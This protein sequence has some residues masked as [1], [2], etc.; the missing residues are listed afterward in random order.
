MPPKRFDRGV[1]RPMKKPKRSKNYWKQRK[2]VQIAEVPKS[3][4]EEDD[5]DESDVEDGAGNDAY[6]KLCATFDTK[7]NVAVESEEESDDDSSE[8]ED[9][10][11]QD[12]AASSDVDDEEVGEES[13]DEDGDVEDSPDDN[14]GVSDE[15]SEDEMAIEAD[16]D[17]EEEA[18]ANDL[19]GGPADP[20]V[21]RYETPEIPAELKAAAESRKYA[22]PPVRETFKKIGKLEAQIPDWRP[23]IEAAKSKKKDR[24]SKPKVALDGS[25]DNESAKKAEAE[26]ILNRDSMLTAGKPLQKSAMK[27]DMTFVKAQLARNV[28]S[29]NRGF[30]F[31]PLQ[32][33]LYS[34][35]SSYRDL[36]YPERTFENAEEIRTVYVLHALN[37]VLK[38]RTRIL[39]NNARLSKAAKPGEMECRDQGLVR[40]KVLIVVPFRE[41]A[42]RVV[43]LM[44]R[45]LFGS[46]PK[47]GSV[48]NR[49]RFD[50][51][52]DGAEQERR[53]KPDDF[54]DTFSGNVDDGFNLGVAVTK[55]T[56]KLYTDF[57]SSDVIISSPLG[58]RMAVGTE[59]DRVEDQNHD[60]LASL[61]LLVL[62]QTDVFAMQNW[63]HV[64]HLFA[65]LH[66]QPR[67]SHGVDFTR[68]RLWTLNGLSGLYRQTLFFGHVP[69]AE[70]GALFNRSCH[71][72][73][74]RV[75][76]CNPVSGGDAA[77]GRVLAGVP[78]AFHRFDT[79]SV[80][81]SPGHRLKYF[82]SR[83]MPE[84]KKDVMF[85][86]CV[87]VPSYFDYVE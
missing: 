45:L 85:H 72:Y 50:T 17:E 78:A 20:F 23:K 71:N 35:V 13:E 65:Y 87:F 56:L 84:Y 49:V 21:A 33:E 41:S 77:I 51:E 76:V 25:E 16:G 59:E 7:K 11:E 57:Y 73:M 48:A 64:T 46:D 31:S 27:A 79:D 15:E 34:L 63:E 69:M 80:T 4:S 68:V 52:F 58:L 74:G 12:V 66:R 2:T 86:T 40:P 54:Y 30:S 67:Q 37:H 42:K 28:D 14:E 55:K 1:K 82:A 29:A 9:A 19:T 22:K 53:G 62:D 39:N 38:T 18:E 8:E 10:E 26:A 44:V 5:D 70:A 43:N 47:G 3:D 36:Y 81:N 75:K 32:S 24:K 60:F 61:E 6:A 83:I